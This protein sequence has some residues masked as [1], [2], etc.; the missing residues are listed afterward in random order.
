MDDANGRADDFTTLPFDIHEFKI[1]VKS[2]RQG[3]PRPLIPTVDQDG[4][5]TLG[6][7]AMRIATAL[8]DRSLYR[9]LTNPASPEFKRLDKVTA[10]IPLRYQPSLDAQVE[11]SGQTGLGAQL[12]KEYG[13]QG[14][15]NQTSDGLYADAVGR[16]MSPVTTATALVGD[17]R[18]AHRSDGGRDDFEWWEQPGRFVGDVGAQILFGGLTGAATR[19]LARGA[20]GVAVKAGTTSLMRQATKRL[21]GVA[22]TNIGML[23]PQAVAGAESRRAMGEHPVEAYGKAA[24][25]TLAGFFGSM[26]ALA[27]D[28]TPGERITAVGQ[29]AL[30]GLGA[31]EGVKSVGEF[32]NRVQLGRIVPELGD[33]RLPPNVAKPLYLW[34]RS[35]HDLAKSDP[36]ALDKARKQVAH[37]TQQLLRDDF[38]TAQGAA[39]GINLQSHDSLGVQNG[40]I[41][42]GQF[43]GDGSID[44]RRDTPDSHVRHELDHQSEAALGLDPQS[45]ASKFSDA[46]RDLIAGHVYELAMQDAKRRQLPPDKAKAFAEYYS[47]RRKRL[48]EGY[49]RIN[50][51][52]G[53]GEL[54]RFVIDRAFVGEKPGRNAPKPYRD[55]IGGI[56]PAALNR[57]RPERIGHGDAARSGLARPV[58]ETM[59]AAERESRAADQRLADY[60]AVDAGLPEA[61]PQY[62]GQ[63]RPFINRPALP[64][65]GE[66][67][68]PEQAPDGNVGWGSGD[69][70][71]QANGSLGDQGPDRL[72]G[73]A[74]GSTRARHPHVDGW[75]PMTYRVVEL[76][77]LIPSHDPERFTED[78][79]YDQSLQ[80][81]DRALQ[82]KRDQVSRMAASLDATDQ[83]SGES[84]TTSE[85]SPIVGIDG[86][87][88]GGNGRVMAMFRARRWHPEAW[89]AYVA[90]IRAKFPEAQ[91]MEHP[92]LVR[93]RDQAM[94]PEDRAKFAHDTNG[95]S[96]APSSQAENAVTDTKFLTPDV[97]DG[98]MDGAGRAGD[99]LGGASNREVREAFLRSLPSTESST[100]EADPSELRKRLGNAATAYVLGEDG[101]ALVRAMT[102]DNELSG[103]E[104]AIHQAAVPLMRSVARVERGAGPSFDIRPIL[105]QALSLIKSQRDS[106]LNP[107]EFWSQGRFDASEYDPSAV[108]L[109]FRIAERQ[110]RVGEIAQTL[111]SFADAVAPNG[112]LFGDDEVPPLTVHDAVKGWAMP[113][114]FGGDG[115]FR[116][117]ERLKVERQIAGDEPRG[118]VS[119][120]E[121]R[122]RATGEPGEIRSFVEQVL[123]EP[124]VYRWLDLGDR[125]GENPEWAAQHG[126]DLTGFKHV[127]DSNAINHII[128][129]HGLDDSGSESQRGQVALTAGDFEKLRQVYAD[130][131]SVEVSPARGASGEKRIVYQ[132][133]FNGHIVAVEEARNN[134]GSLALVTMWKRL[135]R[136]DAPKDETSNFTAEPLDSHASETNVPDESR[137]SMSFEGEPPLRR[138]E[139][140]RTSDRPEDRAIGERERNRDILSRRARVGAGD[141]PG[142]TRRTWEEARAIADMRAA[143]E[144][145]GRTLG[146]KPSGAGISDVEQAQAYAELHDLEA[147]IDH[148]DAQM[149]EETRPEYQ[150]A[151][152][153]DR[154]QAVQQYADLSAKVMDL[155]SDNGR[156][157]AA[158]RM[159]ASSFSGNVERALKR[160]A[161]LARR[162]LTK[163]EKDAITDAAHDVTR[164][165]EEIDGIRGGSPESGAPAAEGPTIVL[166]AEKRHRAA[167]MLLA[168]KIE[169]PTETTGWEFAKAIWKASLL[170][171]L[172]ASEASLFGN[173][174]MQVSNTASRI[175]ASILDS[176]LAIK[177]G[178]RTVSMRG[179]LHGFRATYSLDSARQAYS[180]LVHGSSDL[181]ALKGDVQ[182]KV[183]YKKGGWLTIALSHAANKVFDVL[184]TADTPVRRGEL[185][186]A[187]QEAAWLHAKNEGLK[188]P[189]I[190]ARMNELLGSDP[191]PEIVLAAMA[192]RIRTGTPEQVAIIDAIRQAAFQREDE[193]VMANSSQATR[194][195]S[196]ASR[197]APIL[198]PFAKIPTN[199][200]AQGLEHTPAGGV[201]GMVR[202]VQALTG[203]GKDAQRQAATAIG[204]SM[205]GAG[206]MTL[207]YFAYIAGILSLP[208]GITKAERDTQEATGVQG[209]SIKVGNRWYSMKDYPPAILLMAGAML[210]S[211]EAEGEK[212]TPW[213]IAV[214]TG[215][216]TAGA[217]R[218]LPTLQGVTAIQDSQRDVQKA[219]EDGSEGEGDVKDAA[220]NNRFIGQLAGSVI[221]SGVADALTA[222]DDKARIAKSPADNF[223]ADTP[224]RTKLPMQYDALGRPVTRN[225]GMMSQVRGLSVDQSQR[226]QDPVVKEITRLGIQ[227]TK[228]TMVS[229]PK[230]LDR[231]LTTADYSERLR[232]VGEATRQAIVDTM[233]SDWYRQA[234]DAE[235]KSEIERAIKVYRT[236]ANKQ[237]KAEREATRQ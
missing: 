106:G 127:I 156:N 37:L 105:T 68:A 24:G 204:K 70:V 187:L 27:K 15:A 8:G 217:I 210:A 115:T 1:A 130:P 44:I 139:R 63:P 104:S 203:G 159:L 110:N 144:D 196:G 49:D 94:T 231:D 90:K 125:E 200:V 158:A 10:Q 163:P 103:V 197:L 91:G 191:K 52:T 88:E 122:N 134:R 40:G 45:V 92:V 235:R 162:D 83:I 87:V 61:P 124:G 128:A 199:A 66:S 65:R 138:D 120:G 145:V 223:K 64:G 20:A 224:G 97:V 169:A 182:R 215:A 167:L 2:Q 23:A 205:T 186:R 98:I 19:G 194:L 26:N 179:S 21:V 189:A 95:P 147:L 132:K 9:K 185:T 108:R 135:T 59:A 62:T 232:R 4:H 148:H 51:G 150:E 192:S 119:F 54:A 58:D 218:D 233:G 190:E 195:A 172:R 81:R 84:P 33:M 79:R 201:Y 99:I 178:D 73:V 28:M 121:G 34:A 43:N 109:A 177:T 12:I 176:I 198:M 175:P 38:R 188:G 161:A 41:I 151:I 211:K 236:A 118:S 102:H 168:Q 234:S 80:P 16:V 208:T 11:Q 14:L 82:D 116:D 107:A 126:L 202:A 89:N 18:V 160:A 154:D 48:T 184:E 170:T 30:M 75:H 133:R 221:P 96:V 222:G 157:L 173:A 180:A 193:A 55:M 212:I 100:V 117:A 219:Y 216:A 143:R 86:H 53:D 50:G 42:E 137:G 77:H 46:D 17:S 93:V 230:R 149:K 225:T 152:R 131:D 111:R 5:Y 140:P 113:S 209:N 6:M 72:G 136:S 227:V 29:L 101:T 166:G 229:N 13:V 85:G 76:N 228:A 165:Q 153:R 183:M 213:N 22:A 237:I 32:R 31:Y 67:S 174:V 7:A 114:G 56:D 123:R 142:V 214:S 3:Q 36:A 207:G 206:L 181:G 60:P 112:G 69:I 57:L 35:V 155:K 220:I 129:H 141:A 146:E 164:I 226:Q 47:G 25:D 78:L 39:R 74:V 71:R 171:A